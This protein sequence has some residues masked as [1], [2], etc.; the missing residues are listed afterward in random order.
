MAP[1][2]DTQCTAF[3]TAIDILGR[4]WT[5]K[6]LNALQ[7]GPLRFCGIGDA[8]P[9]IGDK[10]LSARLKELESK[11]L[12]VRTVDAG[13]PIKVAYA[14]TEQGRSFTKVAKAIHEWG[15]EMVQA[16]QR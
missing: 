13:P 3:Q 14:L 12:L 4:P 2:V 7:D 8:V 9:G 1:Q 11:G 5:A 16:A 6:I 10:V 15:I